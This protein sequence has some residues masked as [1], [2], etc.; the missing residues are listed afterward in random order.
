MDLLKQKLPALA[1]G[2][3]PGGERKEE[4]DEKN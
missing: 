2:S 4:E 3:A 1:A